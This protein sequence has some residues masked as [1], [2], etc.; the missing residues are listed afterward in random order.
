MQNYR[1]D[2]VKGE[3]IQ[4]YISK[5]NALDMSDSS[6]AGLLEQYY[7]EATAFIA[8]EIYSR[9]YSTELTQSLNAAYSAKKN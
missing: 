1:E 6:S 9:K 5:I 4:A 8:S 3:T 7:S 2:R